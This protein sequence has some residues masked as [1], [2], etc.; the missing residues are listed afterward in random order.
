MQEHGF[1]P[2]QALNAEYL[3]LAHQLAFKHGASCRAHFR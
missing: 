2:A 3:E 1:V